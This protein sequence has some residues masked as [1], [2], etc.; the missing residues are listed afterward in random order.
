[1]KSKR[2]TLK[3]ENLNSMLRRIMPTMTAGLFLTNGNIFGA[4]KKHEMRQDRNLI[5]EQH[6]D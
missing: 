5:Q 4:K 6:F 3:I 2:A 1:M